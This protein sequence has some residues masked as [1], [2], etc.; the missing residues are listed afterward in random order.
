MSKK[1][2]PRTKIII[3][4]SVVVILVA[5]FDLYSPFTASAETKIDLSGATTYASTDPS[6]KDKPLDSNVL[7]YWSSAANGDWWK[8]DIGSTQSVSKVRILEAHGAGADY[9]VEYSLNDSSYTSI[10]SGWYDCG[11]GGV[12]TYRCI[13]LSPSVNSRFWR[14]SNTGVGPDQGI[15]FYEF[16][17]YSSGGGTP[18]P[19]PTPTPSGSVAPPSPTPTPSGTEE[20]DGP[21]PPDNPDD[22]IEPQ[23]PDFNI[24]LEVPNGGEEWEIGKNYTIKWKYTDTENKI[25]TF[26]LF[27][28][29][30]GGENYDQLIKQNIA[31]DKKEYEWSIPDDEA[32]IIDEARVLVAVYGDSIERPLINDKSDDNF[33]IYSKS[34]KFL[35][36]GNIENPW[37]WVSLALLFTGFGA[38]LWPNLLNSL[39]NSPLF[40]SILNRG[41]LFSAPLKGAASA[42]GVVYDSKTKK[43]L[44]KIILHLFDAENN[45]LKETIITNDK[46]EFSFLVPSGNYYIKVLS[47]QYDFPSKYLSNRYKPLA[48]SLPEMTFQPGIKDGSYQNIYFGEKLNIDLPN[49]SQRAGL[50]VSIPLDKTSALNL[51]EKAIQRLKIIESILIKIKWP[52]LIIGLLS[53]I[54]SIYLNLTIYNFIIFN[55]YVLLIFLEIYRL[56]GKK[57]PYGEVKNTMRKPLGLAVVRFNNH[58]GKIISTSITGNDG[59]Y[60]TSVNPGSYLINAAKS[61]YQKL[62]KKINLKSTRKLGSIKIV[63]KK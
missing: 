26:A 18:T 29:K 30:D 63:L 37:F 43:P 44:P 59:K 20:P 36:T 24:T 9:V 49:P 48:V 1:N 25:K 42:I 22:P 55:L 45:R 6:N 7:T 16:E 51:K 58:Q 27:L 11:T 12:Y 4:L 15:N 32:Y 21:A 61:G 52:V 39:L 57:K 47:N 56:L 23:T 53:S 40:T 50:N 54:V 33:K 60:T 46:G 5:I 62:E 31:K 35:S 41:F 34:E 13:S 38:I 19:S 3:L 8:V 2:Q 10:G 28:S 14:F 17:L